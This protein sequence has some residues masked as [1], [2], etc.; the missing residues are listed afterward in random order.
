MQATIEDGADD[1]IHVKVFNCVFK[2]L[3]SKESKVCEI[4]KNVLTGICEALFGKVRITGNSGIAEGGD[5]CSFVFS[6][7]L[8]K[9]S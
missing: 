4:H 6:F 5:Q 8:K 3:S 9:V 7:R 1:N 2:E